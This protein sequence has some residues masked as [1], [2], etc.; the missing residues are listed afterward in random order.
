[1]DRWSHVRGSYLQKTDKE[2]APATPGRP[3]MTNRT[4]LI[5]FLGFIVAYFAYFHFF[6]P[7]PTIPRPTIHE[8]TVPLEQ[9]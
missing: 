6:W 8:E 4:K 9:K 1:M 2:E 3:A 5:L 7:D